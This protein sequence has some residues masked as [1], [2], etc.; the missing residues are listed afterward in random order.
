VGEDGND[1]A[2]TSPTVGFADTSPAR[3]RI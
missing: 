3:G 1:W 2:D